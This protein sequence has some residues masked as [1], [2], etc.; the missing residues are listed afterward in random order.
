[1]R[2]MVKALLLAEMNCAHRL[3]LLTALPTHCEVPALRA[4]QEGEG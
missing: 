4:S 2:D 3:P 1:M